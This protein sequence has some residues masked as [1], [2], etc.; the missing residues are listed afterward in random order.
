MANPSWVA[1]ASTARS[2]PWIVIAWYLQDRDHAALRRALDE[3][4]VPYQP[5]RLGIGRDEVERTLLEING[6]NRA[7]RHY[8]TVFDTVE[9]TPSLLG[10]VRAIVESPAR[11]VGT[12]PPLLDRRSGGDTMARLHE[13]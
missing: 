2:S 13:A 8:A 5:A 6:Y 9:W 10:E 12:S 4:R 1:I 3:A 7:E 11:A